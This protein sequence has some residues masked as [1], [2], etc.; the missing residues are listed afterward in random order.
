MELGLLVLLQLQLALQLSVE[1]QLLLLLLLLL[2]PPKM[3]NPQELSA[4]RIISAALSP[5]APV[6]FSAQAAAA[7]AEADSQYESGGSDASQPLVQA[8]APASFPSFAVAC[9]AAPQA[10]DN[11]SRST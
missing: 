6:S 1:T 9:S 5:S 2:L 7:G 10:M 8:L 11:S 3:G 4:P